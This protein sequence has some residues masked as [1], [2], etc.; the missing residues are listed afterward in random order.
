MRELIATFCFMLFVI[1]SAEAAEPAA[2]WC[3]GRTEA[4]CTADMA[5]KYVPAETW[6]NST[7][8]TRVTK[9]RCSVDMKAGRAILNSQFASR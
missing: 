4:T 9:A 5:C 1:G 8:K 2:N 6:T 3:K 7:G